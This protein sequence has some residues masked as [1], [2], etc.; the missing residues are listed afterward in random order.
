MVHL[1]HDHGEWRASRRTP[2]FQLNPL[3]GALLRVP[4]H[5]W[6]HGDNH[7]HGPEVSGDL[8]ASSDRH[9][10]SADSVSVPATPR[11]RGC[12]VTRAAIEHDG[13]TIRAVI[14]EAPNGISTDLTDHVDAMAGL[15]TP[16]GRKNGARHP[17]PPDRCGDGSTRNA[18]LTEECG[19][20]D[21][22]PEHHIWSSGPNRVAP[23]VSGA[24]P[25]ATVDGVGWC[26]SSA[27]HGVTLEPYSEERPR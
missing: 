3:S 10:Q 7:G 5:H 6:A 13:A 20:V 1:R 22:E 27:P 26:G 15:V 12:V 9:S 8:R 14:R 23:T 18:V 25:T 2:L 4:G 16:G 17:I 21:R 19:A 24:P 11:I